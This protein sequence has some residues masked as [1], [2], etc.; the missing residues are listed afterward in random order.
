M[1]LQVRARH[2][3]EPADPRSPGPI[4]L[5]TTLGSRHRAPLLPGASQLPG[6]LLSR[7]RVPVSWRQVSSEEHKQGGSRWRVPVS[8]RQVSS[9]EHKQGGSR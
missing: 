4:P 5:H 1:A 6:T 7:W 3:L 8:W 9:E 2:S